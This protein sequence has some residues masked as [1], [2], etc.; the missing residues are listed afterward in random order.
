MTFEEKRTRCV[1]ISIE[2]LALRDAYNVTS[3]KARQD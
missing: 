2:Y 3:Y 1:D